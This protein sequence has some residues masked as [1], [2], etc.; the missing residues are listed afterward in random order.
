MG[1][2]AKGANVLFKM[3][4]FQVGYNEKLGWRE[5]RNVMIK[6]LNLLP[7][8]L[9]VSIRITRVCFTLCIPLSA[10]DKQYLWGT[11]KHMCIL[12]V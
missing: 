12:N 7:C 10:Q 1:L 6:A 2:H 9:T 11:L 4:G 8:Q 3:K 5:F